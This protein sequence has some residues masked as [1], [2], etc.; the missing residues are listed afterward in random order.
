MHGMNETNNE[1]KHLIAPVA[2]FVQY[3]IDDILLHT[4]FQVPA[5]LAQAGIAGEFGLQAV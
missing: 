1:L 4:N 5:T 3:P 2:F